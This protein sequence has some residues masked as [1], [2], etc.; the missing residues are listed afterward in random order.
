MPIVTF[1]ARVSDAML[2]V[3]A[4]FIEELE[5]DHGTSWRDVVTTV[6]RP[7]AF[8]NFDKFVQKKR[9]EYTQNRHRL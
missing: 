8:Y 5:R 1:V 2:L 3:H 9:K 7:Y 4:G 6:A